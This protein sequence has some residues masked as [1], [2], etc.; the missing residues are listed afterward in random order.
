MIST[1]AMKTSISASTYLNMEPSMRTF[2]LLALTFVA[3]N[4]QNERIILLEESIEFVDEI[5]HK[6]PEKIHNRYVKV[7]FHGGSCSEDTICQAAKV[8]KNT[9]LNH[10][11]LHRNLFEYAKNT[12]HGNCNVT[13]SEEHSIERFL[14]KIKKCCQVLNSR[15]LKSLGHEKRP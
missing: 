15:Q 11:K 1:E 10:S 5:L 13:A 4:G 9:F 8:L 12:G 7:I 6:N 3:I 2:L 14:T